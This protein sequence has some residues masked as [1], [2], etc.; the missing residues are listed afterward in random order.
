[1]TPVAF[2]SGYPAETNFEFRVLPSTSAFEHDMNQS[3]ALILS[4]Q[5]FENSLHTEVESDVVG[6]PRRNVAF[7]EP[8]FVNDRCDHF[9]GR[10]GDQIVH[11][12]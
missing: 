1:M 5:S 7:A 8:V 11:A 3:A 10:I 6:T 4:Q 12:A 2:V 9:G